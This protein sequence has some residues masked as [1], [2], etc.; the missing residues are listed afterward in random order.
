M[1][2]AMYRSKSVSLLL[3]AICCASTPALATPLLGS[4]A[5]FVVLSAST[6]TNTGPATLLGD[7][8]IYSDFAIDGIG[9]FGSSGFSGGFADRTAVPEP[10]SLGILG[11]ALVGLG[12]STRR[13]SAPSSS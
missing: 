8:G 1:K 4:A 5:T 9:D 3:M 6:V 12:F 10:A 7:L 13:R 2:D 11:L